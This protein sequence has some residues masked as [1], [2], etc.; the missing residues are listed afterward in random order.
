[1]FYCKPNNALHIVFPPS[2]DYTQFWAQFCVSCILFFSLRHFCL[3]RSLQLFRNY[4]FVWMFGWWSIWSQ[5]RLVRIL[6]NVIVFSKKWFTFVHRNA[7]LKMQHHNIDM[8]TRIVSKRN[9]SMEN[10]ACGSAM[11]T[12]I[13]IKSLISATFSKCIWA[14]TYR[15]VRWSGVQWANTIT[16]KHTVTW[17]CRAGDTLIIKNC[18]LKAF[19]VFARI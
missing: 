2:R 11:A 4:C 10:V 6:L 5:H 17:L 13:T 18:V 14:H 19:K 16:I 3:I 12:T 15:A 8:G 9:G 1:M 7:C